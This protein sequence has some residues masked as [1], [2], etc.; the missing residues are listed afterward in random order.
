M[1]DNDTSRTIHSV[2]RASEIILALADEGVM[3]VTELS[4]K[5]GISKG[6]VHT[7]LTTLSQEGFTIKKDDGYCL[8]LRFLGI[9]EGVKNRI[10]V[11]DLVQD[12]VDSLAE[13]TGERAQFAV[14]EDNKSVFVYRARGENAVRASVKIGEYE[15]PHCIGV[16]K[17]MLAYLP[18][19]RLETVIEQHGLPKRTENTISDPDELQSELDTIREREYAIDDEERVR[20][21]RCVATALRDDVGRVLGGISVSGPARRL[22]DE[23][24]ENDLKDDL[25]RAANVIEV[26]VELS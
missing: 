12:E 1:D 20:G 7:H 25:L 14:L 16:G 11:Y 22:T 5:L 24:I 19:H 8:S 21:I 15:Y 10:E 18:T 9:A 2:E 13:R 6:T 3:G 23:R 4:S 17:A 26:N